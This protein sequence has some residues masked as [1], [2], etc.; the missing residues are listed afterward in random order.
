VALRPLADDAARFGAAYPGA[1]VEP[2]LAD[3]DLVSKG[4]RRVAG[5]LIEKLAVHESDPMWEEADE[6]PRPKALLD[7]GMHLAGQQIDPGKQSQRAVTF[8]FMVACEGRM[9]PGFGDKSG[10]VLPIAWIPGFPSYEM[11]A[12]LL[13]PPLSARRTATSR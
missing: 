6:F 10:A 9:N 4:A 11:I 2:E 12:T 7:T 3:R 1:G 5:S 13:A 8:V